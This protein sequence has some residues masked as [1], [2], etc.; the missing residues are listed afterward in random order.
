MEALSLASVGEPSLRLSRLY[1]PSLLVP[2]FTRDLRG[3]GVVSTRS[4]PSYSLFGVV[5]AKRSS[6]AERS[7][8]VLCKTTFLL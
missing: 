4:C 2:C 3:L 7:A 8:E 6:A 1:A 5:L